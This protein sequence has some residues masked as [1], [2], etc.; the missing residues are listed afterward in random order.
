MTTKLISIL[1][2]ASLFLFTSCKVWEEGDA[3]YKLPNLLFLDWHGNEISIQ[4][5]QGKVLIVDV[6]A[7][8]C[9]PCEKAVPVI[10]KMKEKS[11]DEL[12]FLGINTDTN[13]SPEEIENHAK[14][15][16]MS[17]ISLLDPHH[18]FVDLFKI[19]GLP[20]LIV[21]SKN[22]NLLYRQYGINENDLDGLFA[23]LSAWKTVD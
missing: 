17:Y 19:E 21:F 5:F 9:E 14:Q 16:S 2:T 4:D 8:W 7:T 15:L 1:L 18:V 12:V 13:K 11:G 20:A 22:G 23:R 10:E 6:W 3:V